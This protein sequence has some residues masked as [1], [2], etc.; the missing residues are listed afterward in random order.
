MIMIKKV[1]DLDGTD[2]VSPPLTWLCGRC[3]KKSRSKYGFDRSGE[4]VC[5]IGYDAACA[6]ASFLCET[7]GEGYE[8]L[9]LD[10]VVDCE[11]QE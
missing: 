9:A 1:R 4:N 6:M 10:A 5:D 8:A 7:K 3:G 2:C 11:G